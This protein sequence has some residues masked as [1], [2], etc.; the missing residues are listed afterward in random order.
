[1][2]TVTLLKILAGASLFGAVFFTGEWIRSLWVVRNMNYLDRESLKMRE[3]TRQER[4]TRG[5]STLS[6]IKDTFTVLGDK[7]TLI[8]ALLLLYIGVST[9]LGIVIGT[10]VITLL[11]SVP[12]TIVAAL[13]ANNYSGKRRRA[14]GVAQVLS[15]LR[16]TIGYLESG[17]PP[18]T[19]LSRAANA[20]EDPLREDILS[21]L[22]SMVGT[23]GLG[24]AMRPLAT[25]YPGAA[26]KLL[27]AALEVNDAQGSHLVPVLRQAEDSA[28]R[29]LELAAEAMAEV[30]SARSQ[31]KGV[32]IITAFVAFVLLRSN[33]EAYTGIGALLV[34]FLGVLNYMWGVGRMVKIIGKA[35]AGLE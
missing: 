23:M 25:L 34:I 30:A 9:T 33:V 32:S 10:N 21:C 15:V 14:K 7:Q 1:M 31:F 16:L 20:V 12:L 8:V 26:T 11:L 29:R 19:A 18:N 22:N 17:A 3:E 2:A 28:R 5:T 35:K 13:F 27:V 24:E 4:I 6:K